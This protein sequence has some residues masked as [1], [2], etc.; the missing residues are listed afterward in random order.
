[1]VVDGPG[2]PCEGTEPCIGDIDESGSVGADDL[3]IVIGAWGE[4]GGDVNGDGTT[5]ADDLL[6]LIS[7]W[8]S[9]PG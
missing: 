7:A 3:L 9:C 4:G 8:G 6:M 5:N 1:L 2:L